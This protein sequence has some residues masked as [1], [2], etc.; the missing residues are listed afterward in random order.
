VHWI[1]VR[2]GMTVTS[3]SVFPGLF[4]VGDGL[5]SQIQRFAFSHAAA[6][7]SHH[8]GWPTWYDMRLPTASLTLTF[9]PHG[10]LSFQGTIKCSSASVITAGVRFFATYLSS[11]IKPLC[12][13][14]L[15]CW[16]SQSE[17]WSC[18]GPDS[19]G[20]KVPLPFLKRGGSPSP[21]EPVRLIRV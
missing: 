6:P 19:G 2:V 13:C 1:Y 9:V 18:I 17:A 3:V 11:R 15:L 8:P 14:N 20:P 16:L 21:A 5:S 12:T 4:T 10:A 7:N